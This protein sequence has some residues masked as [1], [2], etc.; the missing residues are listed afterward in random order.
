MSTTAKTTLR[1]FLAILLGLAVLILSGTVYQLSADVLI[2]YAWIK[3]TLNHSLMLV[4]SIILILI[5]NKGK[6]SGYGFKWNMK[7]PI[8]KVVFICLLLG[9]TASLINLIDKNNQA[10][11]PSSDFSFIEKVL[12][13][14]LWASICEE[15]LTRGLIQGFLYPL[16]HIGFQFLHRY[17]SLPVIIGA[18]F[19]GLMHLILLTLGIS[20]LAVL[21]IVFFGIILGIIAGYY[22]EQTGSIVP[23]IIVHMCFNIGGNILELLN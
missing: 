13:I 14:W 1:I 6:L 5:I 22:R 21:D 23:A 15:V 18:V 11:F 3:K 9:F 19:F 4:F 16:K 10:D 8:V 2:P 20:F 7:I 17:I 12:F